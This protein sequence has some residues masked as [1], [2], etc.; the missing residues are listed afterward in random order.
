MAR[1]RLSLW[2]LL[3]VLVLILSIPTAIYHFMNGRYALGAV[4]LVAALIGLVALG[5][6]FYRGEEPGVVSDAAPILP[7]WRRP[8]RL[9][10]RDPS[11]RVAA[12]PARAIVAG[13]S[14]TTMMTITLVSAYG[15]LAWLVAVLPDANTFMRWAKNLID[16]SLTQST[17]EDLAALLLLHFAA[18]IAWALLY[19]VAEPR[20]PGSAWERGVLFSMLPWVISLVVFLPIAGG[21]FLGLSLGAGPL[22]IIGNLILHLVYGATLGEVFVSA[23]LLSESGE[24][25]ID[26]DAQLL[27]RVER[28]M[29]IAIV[30]GF[31]AGGLLG[32]VG[33]SIFAPGTAPVVVAAGAAIIGSVVG[34]LLG[35]IA[36]VQAPPSNPTS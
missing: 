8:R 7:A 27:N 17:Q 36:T 33:S 29:A 32:W 24:A 18:G 14:A 19:A 30:V 10:E 31:I 25:A 13:F 3:F 12:W 21:G 35:S 9:P 22:P 5:F 16:N 1:Q 2:D 15:I 34:I 28:T 26:A 23:G 11:G 6:G 4:A 20:L